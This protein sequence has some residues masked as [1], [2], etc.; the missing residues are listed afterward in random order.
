MACWAPLNSGQKRCF[1]ASGGEIKDSLMNALFM[2]WKCSVLIG[3]GTTITEP[4]M[5]PSN[6]NDA[7]EEGVQSRLLRSSAQGCHVPLPSI[8]YGPLLVCL[9]EI[10]R[11][12]I[13]SL[14]I[15]G[16]GLHGRLT[17]CVQSQGARGAQDSLVPCCGFWTACS[18]LE[19][20]AGNN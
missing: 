6:Q 12:K 19:T 8:T 13:F 15:L 2:K 7:G 5:F 14:S 17:S 10:C 4:Q 16:A 1:R 18:I 11:W 20:G 3:N 9:E